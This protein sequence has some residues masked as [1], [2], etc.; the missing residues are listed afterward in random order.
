MIVQTMEKQMIAGETERRWRLISLRMYAVCLIC[1]V[2][3]TVILGRAVY[4]HLSDNKELQWIA[5]KQY[6]AK[7][8]V[9]VRRGKFFDRNGAE[10]AVSLPV[11]S[12]Y[13]DPE[14]VGDRRTAAKE[15]GKVLDISEKTLYEKL[16]PQKRFAW[17]KRRMSYESLEKVLALNIP[18]ISYVEES[19]RFYPN[20]ELASQILGAVGYDSQALGGLEMAYNDILISGKKTSSYK[21]DARGKLY[22]APVGFREQSDVGEIYLTLDKQIQFVTE[23]ALRE[24]VTKFNAADGIAIAMDP[25]NGNILAMASA[26]KFDP[27]QYGKYPISAWRNRPITDGYEPGSTFKVFIVSAALDAGVVNAE[28]IYNCQNGSIKIGSE[29]LHDAHPYAKLSVQDIIKLS[30]NIGAL[31]VSFDLGKEKVY[32]TLKKFGFGSKTGIEYPGEV[33]GILRDYK[34]WQP[35]EQATV[36]FG[37]GLTLTPLQMVSAFSA[38]VNGG[39]L[40]RPHLV[41]KMIDRNGNAKVSEAEVVAN[42]IGSSSSSIMRQMLRRVVEDNG[43][44]KA[45]KSDAYSIGGKTGTAQKVVN[46]R[47][48]AGKYFSSFIGFAPVDEPRIVV[49]VGLDEPRGAY[50]GGS[51]AAP[52]VKEIIERSLGYMAVPS[53]KSQ[54]L[55]T[56]KKA[57][58]PKSVEMALEEPKGRIEFSPSGNDGFVMPDLS[59]YSMR[60]I[61]VSSRD[62]LVDADVDGTGVAVVQEPKPGAIIKRGGKF[63]VKFAMPR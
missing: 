20:S 57:G 4:L 22:A 11:P 40:Y 19:K 8:P 55:M 24:A 9:S 5:D 31:K 41:S 45:A 25:T 62:A 33:S 53:A 49:Y 52:A 54:M 28:T 12:I 43:T 6:N 50:Y 16:D 18:G 42:P 56:D 38:V 59:G 21:R 39:K 29:V 23:K 26:P 36:A 63:S 48:A 51:V 13:A 32:T 1:T 47:Y 17:L 10:L 44:G 61:L 30:S 2:G 27:N 37:Q 3:F 7:I 14:M 58:A 15:L 46:G 60:E 35:V 34:T